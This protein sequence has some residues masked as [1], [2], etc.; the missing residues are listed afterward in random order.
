[1]KALL[2]M[3]ANAIVFVVIVVLSLVLLYVSMWQGFGLD[4]TPQNVWLGL[5]ALVG[6]I[7]LLSFLWWR[8]PG[9]WFSNMYR[10]PRQMGTFG[11]GS[12]LEREPGGA[13]E[14]PVYGPHKFPDG[15]Y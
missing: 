2:V 13:P 10:S 12:Y 8:D 1:M 6:A 15:D 3:V 7:V 4:N 14:K 11:T 9:S 5:A